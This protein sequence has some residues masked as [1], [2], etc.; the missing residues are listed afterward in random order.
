LP[1]LHATQAAPFA[2]HTALA[3]PGW[4]PPLA[5]Q[6]PVGHVVA[7]HAASQVWSGR[8]V[9]LLPAVQTAQVA[10]PVP[11]ALAAVPGSQP[12]ASQ[13]PLRQLVASHTHEP[14]L[15]SRP[16]AQAVH[17]PPFVPHSAFVGGFTQVVPL[18]QP[19]GHVAAS[20]AASQV[21]LGRQVGLLPA[22]Q[23]AQA[24]PPVPHA[25]AADPGS[26]PLASQQPF[27]QLVASHRHEP[28]LHS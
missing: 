22:V 8:Q 15:H 18:Q 23:T 25:L 26:Q 27:G 3:F 11:H 24:P 14:L 1:A 16:V 17:A 13:Q 12:L 9:G 2:P 20:Q 6:Q 5:S 28:F 7:S 10:P 19:V 4:H 21:W